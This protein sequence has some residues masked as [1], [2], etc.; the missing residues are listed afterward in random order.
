M[1][2]LALTAAV[3]F[4]FASAGAL[5]QDAKTVIANAQKALGNPT[6]ITYSGS[7]HDVAFQQCGANATSLFASATH[8]PR[9]PIPAYG[10]VIDPAPPPPRH[11]GA[12]QNFGAGGSPT[13]TAGT[14]FQQVTPQQADV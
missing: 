2:K 8:D 4:A 10:R 9:R 6:S 1:K 13:I 12:T 7:A 5:A 3:S 14:F 11:T